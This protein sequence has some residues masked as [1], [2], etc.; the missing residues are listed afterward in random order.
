MA[1]NAPDIVQILLREV[2]LNVDNLPVVPL[3]RIV[4]PEEFA[5]HIQG[6]HP[7]HPRAVA[8]TQRNGQT[9]GLSYVFSTPTLFYNASLLREAGLNPD[10]PPRTWEQVATQAKQVADRTGKGGMYIACIELDWCTQGLLLSNGARVMNPERTQVTWAQANALDVVRQWQ[11]WV[12]NGAHVKLSGAD[13]SAAF[14][15]GNMGFFLQTSAVQ[16]G[17]INA[18]RD[19]WELRSAAMPQFGDRPA[20]PVNSGAGL[21]IFATDPA[22]QRAAWEFMK[23][24]TSEEAFQIIVTEM[25]YLPLRAGMMD[26]PKYL[27]NW[28]NRRIIEPNISQLDRLEPSLSFPGQN[29]L[30]IRDLFLKSLQDSLIQGA[31]VDQTMTASATRAQDLMPRGR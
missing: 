21:A 8:L 7:Y 22:K 13:A 6:E 1:G 9:Y 14:S 3:E 26:D 16:S 24:F 31:P 29:H 28:P 18:S 2:D 12:N 23:Y 10:N 5:Q 20:V 11:S 17:L 15:A 27:L 30:Q 25:G 19:R 4:S